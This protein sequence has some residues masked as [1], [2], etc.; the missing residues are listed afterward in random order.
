M[1]RCQ[2]LWTSLSWHSFG[3]MACSRTSLTAAC[4]ACVANAARRRVNSFASRG[5]LHPIAMSSNGY[6]GRVTTTARHIPTPKHKAGIHASPRATQTLWCSAYTRAGRP[7][8]H[9][10]VHSCPFVHHDCTSLHLLMLVACIML[11]ASAADLTCARTDAA[12]VAAS[13]CC[14]RGACF[15]TF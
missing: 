15:K 13:A 10:D 14:M 7:A 12:C 8:V 4:M 5:P 11:S 2:P 9:H 3:A 6:A 1:W